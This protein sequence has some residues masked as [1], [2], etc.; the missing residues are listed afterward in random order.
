MILGRARFPI[1][2][3][4]ANRPDQLPHATLETRAERESSDYVCEPI[5]QKHN[6]LWRRGGLDQAQQERPRVHGG[7]ETGQEEKDAKSSRTLAER[8][9]AL[10]SGHAQ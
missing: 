3:G 9:N 8:S 1:R 7:E 2:T 6:A 10:E 4:Q 5:G